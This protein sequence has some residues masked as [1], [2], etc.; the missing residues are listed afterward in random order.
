[1]ALF[2]DKIKLEKTATEFV[3]ALLR[4]VLTDKVLDEKFKINI[5]DNNL[6]SIYKLAKKHD[7]AHLVGAST[8]EVAFLRISRH[9]CSFK[10]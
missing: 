4:S 8:P 9:S 10:R 3:I 1:M 5:N 2:K 6:A 7:V